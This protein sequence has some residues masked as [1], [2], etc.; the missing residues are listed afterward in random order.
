MKIN[1]QKHVFRF[2]LVM[3]CW[4]HLAIVNGHINFYTGF[5]RNGSNL[6]DNFRG[7]VQVN[8][9][10]VDTHFEAIPRVGTFTGGGLTGGDTQGLGRHTDR[11]RNMQFL[12]NGTFLQVGTDLL[13]VGDVAASQSDADAV[14][15]G[16]FGGSDVLLD[17]GYVRHDVL[18][19]VDLDFR[20]EEGKI[21]KFMS[22][23]RLELQFIYGHRAFRGK[24]Q[25]RH[26]HIP[27]AK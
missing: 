21:K 1:Q 25:F 7:C 13:Q 18:L 3:Y 6:L 26:G 19:V 12:V 8:Q 23:M 4:N 14:N 16:I 17:R 11:T 24:H 22:T 2:F 9:T 20:L 5:N 10:L 15:D 27:E